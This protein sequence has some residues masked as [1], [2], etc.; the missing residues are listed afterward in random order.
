ML[1]RAL[2]SVFSNPT[3]SLASLGPAVAD[4]PWSRGRARLALTAFAAGALLVGCGRSAKVVSTS[5]LTRPQLEENAARGDAQAQTLLGKIYLEG[6]RSEQTQAVRYFE[7]AAGQGVVEAHYYLGMMAEAGRG[8]PRNDTNALQWYRK[9]A[10]GG[11]RDAQYSLAVMY[12]TGRGTERQKEESVKWFRAAAEQG[13]AEAQFN[14]GQRYQFGQGV[15]TNLVEAYKWFAIAG[16]QGIADAKQTMT[17]LRPLLSSQQI[18]EAEAA[19]AVFQ[20]RTK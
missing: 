17:Q 4:P 14:L 7:A 15:P 1:G 12:A 3:A 20:P 18:R 19:A 13:L 16:K 10:E 9:A 2:S 6:P 11:H 5:T 8:L